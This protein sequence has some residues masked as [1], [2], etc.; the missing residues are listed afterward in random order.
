MVDPI[1]KHVRMDTETRETTITAI[2]HKLETSTPGIEMDNTHS[3]HHDMTR[4][5]AEAVEGC[6]QMITWLVISRDKVGVVDCYFDDYAI[7]I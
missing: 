3:M 7:G 1:T 5:T 2:A 6:T 4:D